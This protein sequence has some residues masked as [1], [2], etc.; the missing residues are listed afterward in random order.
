MSAL[1]FSKILKQLK[2][3]E[4]KFNLSTSPTERYALLQAINHIADEQLRFEDDHWLVEQYRQA[5]LR[6]QGIEVE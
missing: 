2:A 6:E 5:M 4:N 1:D 3:I